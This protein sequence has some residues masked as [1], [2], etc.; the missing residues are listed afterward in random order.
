MPSLLH[1]DYMSF[2]SGIIVIGAQWG[3]EGK[4]KAI[5]V[6]SSQADYVVR[7]QGG[8]NAGHT[9][10]IKGQRQVL[11]LIPSGIFH[12][13]TVCIIAPGVAVDIAALVDEIQAVKQLGY[14]A[15]S[16]QLLI[17]D[18][19]TV[20][21]DYH[22]E[23]DQA[24]EDAAHSGKIGTTGKGIGPAYEDR[25]SRKALLFGDLFDPEN[26]L[27]KK[28]SAAIAEKHFLIEKFY[29]KKPRPM[30]S[31][32]QDILVL[33]QKLEC[34]RLNDISSVIHQAL[35]QKKKVLFEGAQGGLL[36]ILHGTY[37]YVTSSNTLASMA[38]VS[39]GIGSAAIQKVVAI[40]KSYT[41]R[42]GEG[43]F[44]TECHNTMQGYLRESGEEWGATTGR[45]R[46][47]GWLDL[48]AL[49]YAT[50]INGVTH[51]ALMKLDILSQLKEIP[52]CTAYKLRGKVIS[53]FPIR[54]EDLSL[55][56]PIYEQL[57]GWGTD[58]SHIKKMADL[59][60]NAY[61]YVQFIQK[62]LD[63]PIDVVSIGVE[64][65]K[66]IQCRPLF[67]D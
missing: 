8:V 5:D 10:Y 4:G 11:H 47:C 53:H 12:P 7:Y 33:R 23:L 56:E 13:S 28:L 67:N 64:R 58:I 41:T 16:S 42:V 38:L 17:S 39:V 51:L 18:S 50:R 36:D 6:F 44:P 62:K 20:L 22:R 35:A 9:L 32:L 2:V 34:H 40:V 57:P 52:V 65:E 61:N 66:I 46:R 3:D 63:I 19:A 43:P 55:C 31:I 1:P 26:I 54:S 14:L 29:H 21:L 49:S 37:P 15:H 25:A 24:R 45:A 48:V 30:S 59:P 27:K 60:T